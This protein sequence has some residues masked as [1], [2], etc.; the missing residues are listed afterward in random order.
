T[1]RDRNPSRPTRYGPGNSTPTNPPIVPLPDFGNAPTSS[2][3]SRRTPS[4]WPSSSSAMRTV[5]LSTRAWFAAI[6]FSRR[7]STHLTARP[8]RDTRVPLLVE[9]LLD[10]A[11][12]A[13]EDRVELGIGRARDVTGDIRAALGMHHVLGVVDG[14]LV[15]DDRR[16]RI[17]L[18]LDEVGGVLGE[19]AALGHN[20]RDRVA[21]EAHVAGRERPERRA[22][23]VLQ[24][25]ART[26]EPVPGK[27]G[28][29][30]DRVPA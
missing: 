29:D 8:H 5:A 24:R 21:D 12:G 2:R 13:R 23:F 16:E 9:R 30:E 22:A 4:M 17:E 25:E 19:V 10:D 11:R 1:P 15:V 7:S 20:E 14:R 3:W 26:H 28:T 6:R 27:V 18:D